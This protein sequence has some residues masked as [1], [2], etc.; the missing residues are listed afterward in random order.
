MISY[1]KSIGLTPIRVKKLENA[2]HIFSHVEWHMTGYEIIV[3]ELEKN[4]SEKMIFA[5]KEEIDKIYP[6]PAAFSA[7]S[8]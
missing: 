7:Y 1:G 3:D 2:K 6:I 4:C 5:G 8:I